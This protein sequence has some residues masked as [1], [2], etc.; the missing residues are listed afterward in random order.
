M[1]LGNVF[2]TRP[3]FSRRSSHEQQEREDHLS[4]D[5]VRKVYT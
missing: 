3:P 4:L 1:H 2:G 5:E